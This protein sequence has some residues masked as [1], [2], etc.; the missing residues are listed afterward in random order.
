VK[1]LTDLQI[2]GC[3]LHKNAFGGRVPPGPAGE[4]IAL[5]KPRVV[6]RGRGGEGGKGKKRVGN[7]KR[8]EGVK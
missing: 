2:L 1:L 4:A 5:P 6:I 7:M 3:K 8:E